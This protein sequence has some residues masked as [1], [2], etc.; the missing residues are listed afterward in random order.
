[1]QTVVDI[2]E[3]VIT[4]L[5]RLSASE[6]TSR[7]DLLRQALLPFLD[8]REPKVLSPEERKRILDETFGVLKDFPEDGLAFQHRIRAEWD[9][10]LDW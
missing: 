5:D 4:R 2:P 9:R 3:E 6:N 10:D 8:A 1:M 7:D